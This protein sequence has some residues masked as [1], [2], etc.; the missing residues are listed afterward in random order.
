MR[1]GAIIVPA[2]AVLVVV[3][4]VACRDVLT[5]DDVDVKNDARV[6]VPLGIS[7]MAVR[8]RAKLHEQNSYDWIGR[9]HNKALDDLRQE[10]KKPGVVRSLCRYLAD[11]A[12][13]SD[14]LP[15]EKRA[16]ARGHD[17][18]DSRISLEADLC[19]G[20][21]GRPSARLV[22]AGL[23]SPPQAHTLTSQ[24]GQLLSDVQTAVTDASDSYDLA[25]RLQP[26]LDASASLDTIEQAAV[27]VTISVA[28]N[29]VEYAE[30][31]I[32]AYRE[33]VEQEYSSC[34]N[35]YRQSGYSLEDAQRLCTEGN[36]GMME[37]VNPFGRF[38]PRGTPLVKA[39]TLSASRSCVSL[40]AGW[41]RVGEADV[42]GAVGGFF[43]G[44]AVT[45]NLVGAGVAALGGS[46]GKSASEYFKVGWE[47][48]WCA[49]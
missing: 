19:A 40:S 49:M 38:G 46:V 37:T 42:S 26:I 45:K 41:K 18:S 36:G 22:N 15:K 1:R 24:G 44:L 21:S 4:L 17:R 32:P 28:Q 5:S 29:S 7:P 27:R 33:A 47:L 30:T 2:L 11:F 25:A 23:T 35:Q 10:V 20:R 16:L 3:T 43:G 12:T 31:E 48:F 8:A 6:T 13:K 34:A 39:A 14:R 9:A